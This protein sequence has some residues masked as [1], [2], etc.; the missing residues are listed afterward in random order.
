MA[1][2]WRT[3]LTVGVLLF[4]IC[5]TA[6]SLGIGEGALAENTE[7]WALLLLGC[8]CSYCGRI[9]A[10]AKK[11]AILNIGHKPITNTLLQKLT[12]S[13]NIVGNRLTD[14]VCSISG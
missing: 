6:D 1:H 10:T 8:K 11:H 9:D 7:G 13:L 5:L 14:I 12:V 3:M 4:L 2:L